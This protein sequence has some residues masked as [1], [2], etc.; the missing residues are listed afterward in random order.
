MIGFGM[1]SSHA[2]AMFCEPELW[3]RVY[4]A[5]PEYTKSS[6]PHTAKGE[7]PEVIR[8]YVARI[9]AAFDFLRGELERYRPDALIVVGDDQG[10]MF[11]E[12]NNPAI[13][14]FRGDAVWG[15][16]RPFFYNG[17]R[18]DESYITLKVHQ[19]LAELLT[20]A[21]VKRGFDIANSLELKPEG[22]PD[23]GVSHMLTYPMPRL[24]PKLDVPVVPIFVNAYYP[25]QP[26]GRRCWELGVALAEILKDRPER[27]AIY[28]SGG[29]SHDPNGPLAGWIDEPLD[30]WVFERIES[31]RGEEL[32]SLF[33]FDSMVLRGGTGEL[34]AWITAAGACRWPGKKIEYI[35]AHHAKTGLGFCYWPVREPAR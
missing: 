24:V 34:R 25:P 19:E 28:G 12:A 17:E 7:T 33:S 23:R 2:P 3:P 9:G 26:T 8:S 21:L 27:I 11:T 31:N 6:Q 20:H 10:D 5:I 29:M 16:S 35:A 4:S 22:H 30:R 1:A 14:I 13:S 32:A 15:T 18:P